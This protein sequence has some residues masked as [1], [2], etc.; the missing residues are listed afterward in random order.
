MRIQCTGIDSARKIT[1]HSVRKHLVQKCVDLNLPPTDTV[2]ITGH[3]NLQSVN[4]YSKLNENKQKAISRALNNKSHQNAGFP[5]LGI[6]NQQPA[7][8]L[9]CQQAGSDNPKP[10][11]TINSISYS[12]S[13]LSSYFGTTTIS[14]GT[15]T[16]NAGKASPCKCSR[17]RVQSPSPLRKKF[18]RIRQIESSDSE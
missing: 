7:Y 18:K 12:Q 2:Q 9:A 3:K 14:G 11:G 4:N 10:D 16:F 5:L 13:A 15:F 17:E 6:E 8:T 1:N